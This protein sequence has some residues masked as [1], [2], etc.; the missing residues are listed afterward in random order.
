MG[1]EGGGCEKA[2]C[3]SRC[4]SR[5]RSKIGRAPQG[6]PPH[7]PTH[8]KKDTM[9][10]SVALISITASSAKLLNESPVLQTQEE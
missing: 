4:L 5:E 9:K 8:A 6:P 7:F 2:R 10:L 3:C 1:A